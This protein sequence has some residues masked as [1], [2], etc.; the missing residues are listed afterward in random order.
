MTPRRVLALLGFCLLASTASGQSEPS[1]EWGLETQLRFGSFTDLEEEDLFGDLELIPKLEWGLGERGF[2]RFEARARVEG[3]DLL[4][5]GERPID[6]YS[7]WSRPVTLRDVG[8]VEVREAVLGRDGQRFGWSLGKQQVVWGAIDGFRVLDVVNPVSFR[9]FILEDFGS[10]R[11]PLWSLVLDWKLGRWR[12][13]TVWAPDATVHEIP[14]DG[15]PFA[16]RAPRFRL[17]APEGFA[18]TEVFES[19]DDIDL[20]TYGLRFKTLAAGWDLSF[21]AVS[22]VDPEPL[23]RFGNSGS[24]FVRFHERRDVLGVTLAKAFGPVALRTEIGWQPD[25]W[26]NTLGAAGLQP[27][28]FDQATWALAADV[29]GPMGWFFNA[30]VV[31]DRL[32]DAPALD[33]A[34]LARPERDLFFSLFARRSF[35]YDTLTWELRW[36][37]GDSRP[38]GAASEGQGGLYRSS[39]EYLID[40]ASSVRLEIDWFEGDEN[41]GG[42][43]E[44]FGQFDRSDRVLL[45]WRHSL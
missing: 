31:G 3:G 38:V 40:D 4:E 6:G 15:A 24:T 12:L 18:G 37:G 25:R 42:Y 1:F 27:T 29:Q 20:A 44:V 35:R 22:G 36:Y 17:Q 32:L 43:G 14:V 19:P 10:A 2:A 16:F 23:A 7:Q 9:E 13:E 41:A 8:S 30:Q 39:L 33:Q 21:S 28:R 45:V 26:L 5:P 11:I 34:R